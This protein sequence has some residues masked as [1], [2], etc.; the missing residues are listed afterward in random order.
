MDLFNI[1]S[2]V[3]GLVIGSFGAAGVFVGK[4]GAITKELGEL[5]TVITNA[6]EDKNLTKEELKSILEEAKDVLEA[7]KK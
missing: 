4:V 7:F 2:V 3:I 5:F 1:I 6:L